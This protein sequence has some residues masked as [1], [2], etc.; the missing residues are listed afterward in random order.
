LRIKLPFDWGQFWIV[1]R[2]G[3]A[4]HAN[5]LFHTN[6]KVCHYREGTLLEERD[7]G[8]GVVTLAGTNLM[9]ADWTNASATL[10]LVNWHDSG[11]GA[12]APT[13]IDTALQIPTGITRVA[14]GQSNTFS[15]YQSVG[16]IT[17]TG[18]FTI[19]EWGIWTAVTGGTLW[20]RRT[21]TGQAVINGD[22][23]SWIYLL[24][25]VPG[26]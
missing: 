15:V 8:P 6:L 26:G 22:V 1:R 16:N 3:Q 21:F 23:L 7:L 9:A 14:G 19:T 10:K 5:S 12:V 18:S 2:R 25:I 24:T 13:I 17:Y 11:T 20:D 4:F